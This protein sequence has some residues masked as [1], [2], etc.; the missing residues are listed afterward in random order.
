[1]RFRQSE[2][3]ETAQDMINRN[4]D[5]EDLYLQN[6]DFDLCVINEFVCNLDFDTEWVN[7]IEE[8]NFIVETNI[9]E[10]EKLI[11]VIAY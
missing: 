6:K 7:N 8:L 9:L 2:L 11:G 4:S 10:S 5:P 3:Q 1:M